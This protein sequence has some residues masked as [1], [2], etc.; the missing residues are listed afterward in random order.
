ML[1]ARCLTAGMRT[2]CPDALG[3]HTPY[4]PEELGAPG[5]IDESGMVVVEDVN[6]KNKQIYISLLFNN[7]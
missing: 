7:K 5:Q 4:T 1:F 2:H 6:L 3:G